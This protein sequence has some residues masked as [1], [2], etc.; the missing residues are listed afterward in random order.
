MTY[1][2]PPLMTP[3]T[4]NRPV[5]LLSG[6]PWSSGESRPEPPQV[7]LWRPTRFTS[8]HVG[9]AL[10]GLGSSGRPALRG[11]SLVAVNQTGSPFFQK[12][13]PV[14]SAST[15]GQRQ[16]LLRV[17]RTKCICIANTNTR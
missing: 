5:I 7:G 15:S 17:H 11:I 14:P 6:S 13:W 9:R 2:H 4:C 3:G 10:G 12:T 1:G 8:G 16:S